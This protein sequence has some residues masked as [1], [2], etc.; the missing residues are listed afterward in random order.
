M[1]N[2]EYTGNNNWGEYFFIEFDS[3]LMTENFLKR[4]R[5]DE[6]YVDE[7][8]PEK[9]ITIFVMSYPE[10]LKL[11]MGGSITEIEVEKEIVEPFLKGKYS[12]ISRDYAKTLFA[13][14]SPNYRILHKDKLIKRY[15]EKLLST[16]LPKDAEVWSRPEKED[17][18]LGYEPEVE[19]VME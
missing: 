13:K 10:K 12:Q 17:E 1:G 16:T 15:W 19:T 11:A 3:D 7:F 2:K 4:I 5:S 8:D 9:G 18:I 6:R 14:S